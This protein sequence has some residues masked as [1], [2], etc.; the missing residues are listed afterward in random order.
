MTGVLP[1]PGQRV[2]GQFEIIR[3]IGAGAFT[4][5]FEARQTALKRPV[6][7]KM[8]RPEMTA[9]PEIAQRFE[10][11]AR[12]ASALTSPHAMAVYAFGAHGGLPYLAMELL[13]GHSLRTY[14]Y[15]R[16]VLSAEAA[17]TVA[18]QTAQ[19]LAEAHVQGFIHRDVKPDNLFLVT[20]PRGRLQV[21][22]MDFGIAKAISA[23]WDAEERA[24]ITR[25]GIVCGTPTYMAPEQLSAT[26]TPTPALDVYA[27]GCVLFEMLEG[28][29]PFTGSNAH[30]TAMK[31]LA[32]DPPP[33]TRQRCDPVEAVIRH[34]LVK[35]PLQRLPDGAALEAALAEAA[36]AAGLKVKLD[37]PP[38]TLSNGT[39]GDVAV[40]RD[41]PAA[42][43]TPV[44]T[45]QR[46][47]EP[48]AA[49]RDPARDLPTTLDQPM[50]AVPRPRRVG[51]GVV[52]IALAALTV[53]VAALVVAS[54]NKVTEPPE[55]KTG[56]VDVIDLGVHTSPPGASVFLNS[57]PMGETPLKIARH[58]SDETAE[59]TLS[60]AG[61]EPATVQVRLDS[62]R[63]VQVT[64]TALAP[65]VD[66]VAPPPETIPV[67]R[68]PTPPATTKTRT[69]RAR[70]KE[71]AEPARQKTPTK[72]DAP[73]LKP[74]TKTDY[75]VPIWN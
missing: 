45:P 28:R 5:V 43:P 29:P 22:L 33:L 71:A 32:T 72:T 34:A 14:L 6:A 65:R 10:R 75:S 58:R 66:P 12:L 67:V 62:S 20:D 4:V 41:E 2:D 25:D 18:H 49:P 21:K 42:R 63:Q 37:L 38:L 39:E 8:L 40:A 51:L 52:L 24:P 59:L 50:H 70:R 74:D 1:K 13:D 26:P 9:D 69:T 46:V 64:L 17:L 73:D 36:A 56:V 60:K 11:Q 53:A 61:Y 16:S 54:L 7:L 48:T 23:G 57:K 55:T 47:G 27:V 15:Y 68:K 35:D 31:H 30:E 3:E 19:A 44:K